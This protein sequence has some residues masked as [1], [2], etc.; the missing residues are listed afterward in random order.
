MFVY[1]QD[2]KSFYKCLNEYG[3]AFTVI[4]MITTQV[5][6]NWKTVNTSRTFRIEFREWHCPHFYPRVIAV[7]TWAAE[8]RVSWWCQIFH[9]IIVCTENF[10]ISKRQLFSCEIL[11][12]P[13]CYWQLLGNFLVYV[14]L[15]GFVPGSFLFGM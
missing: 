15:V 1:S 9:K 11:N 14:L 3:G 2:D 12:F 13:I 5:G 10:F 8:T 4:F 6:M 7:W